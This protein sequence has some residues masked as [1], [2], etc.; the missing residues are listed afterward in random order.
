MLCEGLLLAGFCQSV[1]PPKRG[2][3]IERLHAAAKGYVEG[4]HRSEGIGAMET[5]HRLVHWNALFKISDGKVV[6]N[7]CLAGQE[8][9]DAEQG[10]FTHR[11][12]PTR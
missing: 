7:S 10:V 2:D 11:A 9:T 5:E 12:L 1:K 8:L 6:C 3:P 4:A